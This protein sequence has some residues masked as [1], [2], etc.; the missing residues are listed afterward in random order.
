[1]GL[2]RWFGKAVARRGNFGQ[3]AKTI[4]NQYWVMRQANP[5]TARPEILR[6]IVE[7]RH[8][9]VPYSAVQR[10]RLHS[11]AAANPTLTEFVMAVVL[12][13]SGT[14]EHELGRLAELSREVVKE[15]LS[16]CGLGEET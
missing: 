4:G 12:A 6:Q 9:I 11:A 16:K 8:A 13:E 7:F 5:D 2:R 3:T 10:A 14:Y 15:E 1:M